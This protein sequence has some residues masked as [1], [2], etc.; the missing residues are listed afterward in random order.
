MIRTEVVPDDAAF[1]VHVYARKPAAPDDWQKIFDDLDRAMDEIG[2][3]VTDHEI[4]YFQIRL[5]VKGYDAQHL[6]GRPEEGGEYR[7]TAH[8]PWGGYSPDF[9]RSALSD[10]ACRQ[11]V[12]R[13]VSRHLETLKR[14][15]DAKQNTESLWEDDNTQFGEPLMFLLAAMDVT[16]VAH[17]VA[18]IELWDLDHQVE[19]W[20]VI[21]ALLEKYGERP[22]TAALGRLSA[23]KR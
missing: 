14:A 11:R 21:E 20:P 4:T 17:Y 18:F 22:E 8:D 10:P 19:V 16:V 9:W 1:I 13:W 2:T 7:L 6:H 15:Q 12:E 5:R 23:Q 3:K